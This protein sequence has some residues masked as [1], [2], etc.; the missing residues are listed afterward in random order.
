MK[1]VKGILLAVGAWMAVSAT[2]CAQSSMQ[3]SGLAVQAGPEGR[4][5]EARIFAGDNQVRLEHERDGGQMVEIF[6]MKNQR[7]LLFVPDQKVYMQR[8]FPPGTTGNPVMP[9][10]DSNPCASIPEA[11]CRKVGTD[12]LYGRPVSQWEMIIKRNG[13]TLRSLH[14]I[15]DSRHMSL[16]DVWPDGSTTE[17]ILQGK[18]MLHGRATERWEQ[19]TTTKDGKK[20]TTTQW[21]DPELKIAIRE[22]M[23]G[24]FYREI[25]D[26]RVA[27]QPASLFEVPPGYQR[28]E[29]EKPAAA[30][31]QPPGATNNR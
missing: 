11:H 1:W 8:D 9:P 31:G 15:D 10:Q 6:D 13:E 25:R 20:R 4:A 2:V 30:S 18:E 17:S 26:I 19:V 28:V 22:E 12:T 24:G 14:W 29:I 16:R 27:P 3:F 21:Y 23:P 7:V 5:R